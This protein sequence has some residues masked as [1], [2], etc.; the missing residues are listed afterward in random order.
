MSR[1]QTGKVTRTKNTCFKNFEKKQI[2]SHLQSNISQPFKYLIPCLLP[3]AWEKESMNYIQESKNQ[4]PKP[5]ASY[6]ISTCGKSF[7]V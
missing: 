1:K 6:V 3:C 2:L 4:E 7:Y 5:Y